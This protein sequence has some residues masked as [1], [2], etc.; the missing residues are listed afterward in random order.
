MYSLTEGALDVNLY[1]ILIYIYIYILYNIFI[2]YNYFVLYINYFI[3][4][5]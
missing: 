2:F 4:N 3:I 5:I 1:F